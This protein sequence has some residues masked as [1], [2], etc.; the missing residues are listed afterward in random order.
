M[1]EDRNF[2]D[3]AERFAQRIYGSLKGE[4]RQKIIWRDLESHV[5]SHYESG[6]MGVLDLGAGLGHFSVALAKL[7]HKVIYNDISSKMAD[8]AKELAEKEN[9]SSQLEW[10]IGP[11]QNH[12]ESIT[13]PVDLVL[14]HAVIEWLEKPQ[15][16][17]PSLAN[18]L[19]KHGYLSL[20]FYNPVGLIY[21]NLIRGNF[22]WIDQSVNGDEV[23]FAADK[24]GLTPTNP[25]SFERVK[26]WLDE[27]D[28]NIVNVSGIR[29]FSDYVRQK[30]GG[31][32]IP[33][34]VVKRELQY[35]QLEPY[36]W[37]GRYLHIIAVKE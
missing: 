20:C 3:V 14:C 26:Q 32:T 34:E 6:S 5:L 2:D 8:L 33:E 16:L 35:S 12:A 1:R 36:K 37:L 28:L 30:T 22:D 31:N 11:Y 21:H 29:V 27:N 4:L 15:D 13:Q 23:K 9:V 25:S 24:G 18:K 19:N 17:I 7:G 10:L